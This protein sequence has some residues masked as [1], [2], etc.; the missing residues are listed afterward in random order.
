MTIRREGLDLAEV[1]RRVQL[2]VPGTLVS[3]RDIALI[4]DAS[5]DEVILTSPID[6][7][8]RTSQSDPFWVVQI[9][10]SRARNRAAFVRLL[11]EELIAMGEDDTSVVWRV[12]GEPA[13]ER[14]IDL[15]LQPGRRI[16]HGREYR[17]FTARETLARPFIN[18]I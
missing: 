6:L 1:E 16:I 9:F 2:R 4:E 17:E 7:G 10:R 18:G 8:E 15:L 5:Q 13:L 3:E 12:Q 14:A 11:A